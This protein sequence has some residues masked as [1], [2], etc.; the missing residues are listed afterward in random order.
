MADARPDRVAHWRGRLAA[1]LT[2]RE[3]GY[4]VDGKLVVGCQPRAVLSTAGQG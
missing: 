3:E 4:V 1:E 2:G